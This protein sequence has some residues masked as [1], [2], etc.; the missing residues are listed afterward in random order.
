MRW[1]PAASVWWLAAAGALAGMLA[2]PSY[3][4]T[5]VYRIQPDD[6]DSLFAMRN[7]DKLTRCSWL[8]FRR[9]D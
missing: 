8:I 6:L 2:I 5:F 7:S 9:G 3:H 4:L 1:F